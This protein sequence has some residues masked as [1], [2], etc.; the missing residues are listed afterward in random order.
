VP[1]VHNKPRQYYST[2]SNF[3][4]FI[5]FNEHLID[6]INNNKNNEK[7][8]IFAFVHY[9]NCILKFETE[10]KINILDKNEQFAY[11]SK[12]LHLFIIRGLKLKFI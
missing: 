8:E 4:V 11:L 3:K 6:L 12:Q 7:N 1:C 10:I 2:S 5:N 9:I